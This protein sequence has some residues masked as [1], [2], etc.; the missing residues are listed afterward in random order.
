MLV[1][2]SDAPIDVSYD[3]GYFDKDEQGWVADP[4]RAV[5]QG[6]LLRIERGATVTTLRLGRRYPHAGLVLLEPID[7]ER[8]WWLAFDLRVGRLV[9]GRWPTLRSLPWEGPPLPLRSAG[10][11]L[12]VL[13]SL[14]AASAAGTRA[15]Y[16]ESVV[17][18][19]DRAA[20]EAALL[21]TSK[22]LRL[23]VEAEP[24]P[25]V[26]LLAWRRGEPAP[27]AGS[28]ERHAGG[29]P[30][31]A[32]GLDTAGRVDVQVGGAS[33]LDQLEAAWAAIDAALRSG[34]AAGRLGIGDSGGG[35]AGR[36][37]RAPG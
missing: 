7:D 17:A 30:Y 13:L 10:D 9:E 20:L 34:R 36:A 4:V 32:V 3:N 24:G 2:M 31:A 1:R 26:Y 8:S 27:V 33:S 21:D 29:V 23:D 12:A 35:A 16:P 18:A 22:D 5:Q 25:G 19:P 28:A 15:L 11:P 14:V 37:G 6:D